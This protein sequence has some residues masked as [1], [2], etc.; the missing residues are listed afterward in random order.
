MPVIPRSAPKP[1]VPEGPLK[2]HVMD[3]TFGR[4]KEKKTAFFEL[5]IRDLNT[6]LTLKDR[7]YLTPGSSWKA[8]ALCNSMG[9]TLPAGQYRLQIDD[10]VNRLIYG[11]VAYQTLPSGIKLAQM[12]TYWR[13]DWALQQDENLGDIPDP[14]GILGPVELPLVEEAPET[15]AAPAASAAP[16]TSPPREEPPPAAKVTSMNP[17]PAGTPAKEATAIPDK[18][19]MEGVSDTELAEALLYAKALRAQKK[20]PPKGE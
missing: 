14:K 16:I 12:K 9:H 15:P 17:P 2:G 7:V 6:S 20:G 10:L 3:V 13:K 18:V 19:E 1:Q 5:L 11:C 8:D 4:S